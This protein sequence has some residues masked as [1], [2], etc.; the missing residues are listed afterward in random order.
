MV[1]RANRKVGANTTSDMKIPDA[2]KETPDYSVFTVEAKK[3]MQGSTSDKGKKYPKLSKPKKGQLILVK[4]AEDQSKG[5]RQ[6]IFP[7]LP[8]GPTSL[9]SNKKQSLSPAVSRAVS[10]MQ[11]ALDRFRPVTSASGRHVRLGT[12]F[13]DE[14]PIFPEC[15]IGEKKFPMFQNFQGDLCTICF[16][17]QKFYFWG[18]GGIV[19][20]GG[21]GQIFYG[22]LQMVHD[23]PEFLPLFEYIFHH[24][25]DV[26]NGV[27]K[28]PGETTLLTGIARIHE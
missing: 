20:D 23:F 10:A 7:S 11:A 14:I 6:G 28:F 24:E 27:E 5:K 16:C 13:R 18:P 1:K 19:A 26:R 22:K 3:N 4:S 8:K 12:K 2:E 21:P 15:D 17:T 9:V 25:N